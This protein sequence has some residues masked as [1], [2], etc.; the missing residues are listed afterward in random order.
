[1]AKIQSINTVESQPES[2]KKEKLEIMKISQGSEEL[3]R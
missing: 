2:T 3:M 1:M